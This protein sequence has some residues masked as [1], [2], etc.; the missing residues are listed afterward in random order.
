[1]ARPT[2][3]EILNRVKSAPNWA[4]TQE[5]IEAFS[6]VLTG[7]NPDGTPF[8]LPVGNAATE[9]L[10]SGRMYFGG[11]G[12]MSL[13]VAGNLRAVLQN[14]ADSGRV[15]YVARMVVTTTAM[16]WADLFVN[17]TVGVPTSTPRPVTNA[18][19]GQNTSP[20][21]VI[22]ADTDTT[23]ALGGGW[24]TGV[25]I[26]SPGGQRTNLDLPPFVLAPGVTL[27]FNNAFAGAADVSMSVFWWE[28]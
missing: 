26:G 10:A 8:V 16:G 7:K 28:G 17:P 21:G 11:S 25:S 4:Q 19:I 18:I 23:T 24:N 14:P 5:A 2:L 15:M 9:A 1:V 12:K 6:P 3:T 22:R 13:A 27:G 20:K